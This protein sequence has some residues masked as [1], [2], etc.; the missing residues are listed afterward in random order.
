MRPASEQGRIAA[1]FFLSGAAALVYQVVWQRLLFTVVGVD[2]ESVTIVVSTFML[3]LGG[4]ALLG[5]WLADAWPRRIL[6]LFC[7]AEAA[8][9]AFGLASTDL[10][11]GLGTVLAGAPRGLAAAVC[12]A[13]LLLPTLAM[14]ATLPMLVADAFRH[15]S[16]GT[17]SIGVSTGTLYFINTVGAALGAGAVGL[18]LPY[19]LD[20]RQIARLAAGLNLAASAT[21]A[22]LGW[23]R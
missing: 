4:G 13:L 23:R 3:G 22:T 15:S 1:A 17:R 9:G 16:G 6:W 11:L 18:V 20:L 19:W 10:I 8:I 12:F 14:G 2:I 7:G 21:V 5:G